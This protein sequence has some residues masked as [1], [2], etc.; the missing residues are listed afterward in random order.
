LWALPWIDNPFGVL[1]VIGGG[2]TTY[3]VFAAIGF[4]GTKLLLM[5]TFAALVSVMVRLP[6]REET[7]ASRSSGS[8][9]PLCP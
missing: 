5:S 6:G 4:F 9:T 3:F 7:N 1:G 8:C 2:L